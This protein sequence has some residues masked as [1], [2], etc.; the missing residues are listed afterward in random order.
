MGQDADIPSLQ[1]YIIAGEY[2]SFVIYDA[3]E[4]I[5]Y[6]ANAYDNHIFEGQLLK[7]YT[8]ENIKV[9]QD[10]CG[11]LGYFGDLNSRIPRAEVGRIRNCVQEAAAALCSDIIAV[12]CGSYRR[13][14]ATCGD[15]DILLCSPALHTDLQMFHFINHQL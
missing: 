12:T 10:C 8:I 13:G 9:E 7:M 2:P 5:Y 6:N 1:N 3:S 14:K 11:E 15:V 4:N